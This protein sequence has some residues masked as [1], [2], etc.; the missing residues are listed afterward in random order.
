[1]LYFFISQFIETDDM[2][3]LFYLVIVFLFSTSLVLAQ[4]PGWPRQLTNNGQ[5]SGSFKQGGGAAPS[6]EMSGAA[7]DRQRGN[8]GASQWGGSG[9]SRGGFG[10][11]GWGG[12]FGGGGGGFGG[13]R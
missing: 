8:A 6:S 12:G 2:K 7:A 10:G 13:R 1:M 9:G 3:K 5:G 4:D 11:G